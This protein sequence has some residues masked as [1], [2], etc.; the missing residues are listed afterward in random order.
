MYPRIPARVAIVLAAAL[1]PARASG[2]L[3]F[4]TDEHDPPFAAG[5]AAGTSAR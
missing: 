5:A 4:Q 2:F 3:T 1:L